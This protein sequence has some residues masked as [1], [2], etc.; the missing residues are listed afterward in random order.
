[1]GNSLISSRVL[2][3]A[4]NQLDDVLRVFRIIWIG[5]D[6]TIFILLQPVLIDN[7]V[8]GGAGAEEVFKGLGR[9]NCAALR[10]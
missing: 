10:R 8:E 5:S 7:P 4:S 6:C 1:M 9:N 3:L 2:T